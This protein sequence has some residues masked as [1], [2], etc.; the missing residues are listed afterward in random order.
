MAQSLAEPGEDLALALLHRGL[1]DRVGVVVV[2]QVE[3]PVD[4]EEC[5]LVIDGHRVF[6]RLRRRDRRAHHDVADQR[7]G[8]AALGRSARTAPALVGLTARHH[9]VVVHRERQHVGRAGT[10][11][12]P[13]VQLRDR[14]LVDEQERQLGR[15]RHLLLLDHELGEAGPAGEVDRDVALLVTPEHGDHRELWSWLAA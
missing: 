10:A 11:E 4:D 9:E 6:G 5:D 14:A 8:L 13:L 7:R 15:S 2:E 3:H 12:E 1:T